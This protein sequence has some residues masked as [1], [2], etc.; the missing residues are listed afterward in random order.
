MSIPRLELLYGQ[1]LL[2]VSCIE[3]MNKDMHEPI[4]STLQGLNNIHDRLARTCHVKFVLA[5]VRKIKGIIGTKGENDEGRKNTA[6]VSIVDAV[7]KQCSSYSIPVTG[8]L[9]IHCVNDAD[10]CSL[11]KILEPGS[12]SKWGGRPLILV[13][14]RLNVGRKLA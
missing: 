1:R 2:E 14:F 3:V 8:T 11:E 10:G 7:Y 13:V 9:F 12:R 4:L 6:A 5:Y